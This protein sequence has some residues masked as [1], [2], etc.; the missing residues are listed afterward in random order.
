M[1]VN[2]EFLLSPYSLMFL[3]SYRRCMDVRNTHYLLCVRRTNIYEEWTKELGLFKQDSKDLHEHCDKAMD[4]LRRSILAIPSSDNLISG[5][6]GES[7]PGTS[8]DF[9]SPKRKLKYMH[10]P[11]EFRVNNSNQYRGDDDAMIDEAE[12]SIPADFQNLSERPLT[13]LDFVLDRTLEALEATENVLSSDSDRNFSE[14]LARFSSEHASLVGTAS[15][16]VQPSL[17]TSS[18]AAW[19]LSPREYLRADAHSPVDIP[20]V[21]GV[22]NALYSLHTTSNKAEV[23]V[24]VPVVL[25]PLATSERA[26]P[27]GLNQGNGQRPPSRDTAMPSRRRASMGSVSLPSERNATPGPNPN[28]YRSLESPIQLKSTPAPA[29][30]YAAQGFQ[31]NRASVVEDRFRR[32]VRD[33]GYGRV[34]LQSIQEE[35][36]D[37]AESTSITSKQVT[38]QVF[39]IR[40][41]RRSSEPI[42]YTNGALS[43]ITNAPEVQP[44]KR[45]STLDGNGP[46]D[47]TSTLRSAL[48]K[49]MIGTLP[50]VSEAR[51]QSSNK[52]RNTSLKPAVTASGTGARGLSAS[53]KASDAVS[54]AEGIDSTAVAFDSYDSNN[55]STVVVPPIECDKSTLLPPLGSNRKVL[56]K[57]KL[58]LVPPLDLAAAAGRAVSSQ[59]PRKSSIAT[60]SSSSSTNGQAVAAG[61]SE[62]D[63]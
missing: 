46:K 36:D 33:D 28:P 39:R 62:D 10:Q 44:P 15:A 3:T 50:A 23:T 35:S 20:A 53:A 41:S 9:P 25:K 38:K 2:G 17:Q 27:R 49:S 55:S 30:H 51:L 22:E 13:P 43:V 34:R 45:H 6:I 19:S 11:V 42:V 12:A 21:G 63:F 58:L 48:T 5:E 31:E 8:F 40:G 7:S 60:P 52:N 14:E 4:L 59:R 61:E 26:V 54:G 18:G 37:I 16:S 32:N 1:T 24:L 56:Q 47:F 57:G 29:P